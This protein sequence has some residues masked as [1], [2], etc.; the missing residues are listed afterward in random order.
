MGEKEV[1]REKFPAQQNGLDGIKIIQYLFKNNSV[2][3]L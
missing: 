2:S 1:V 3:F